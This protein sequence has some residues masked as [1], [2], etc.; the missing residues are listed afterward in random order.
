MFQF[1]R[2]LSVQTIETID[3]KKQKKQKKRNFTIYKEMSFKNK[4]I[5][6]SLS[7]I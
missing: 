1:A 7:K 3:T 2:S 5:Y 6:P 4:E